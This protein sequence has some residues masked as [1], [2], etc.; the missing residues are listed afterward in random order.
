MGIRSEREISSGILVEK[1]FSASIMVGN[2]LKELIEA[3]FLV[4]FMGVDPE[5]IAPEAVLGRGHQR[6]L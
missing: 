5:V 1:L 3:S 2:I 6:L 4:L